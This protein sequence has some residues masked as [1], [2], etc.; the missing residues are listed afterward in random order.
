MI[1]PQDFSL[2]VMKVLSVVLLNPYFSSITN[3]LY[4]ENG[5]VSISLANMIIPKK[6]RAIRISLSA[7]LRAI[8][9]TYANP[10][11]KR[12]PSI[13]SN[14]KVEVTTPNLYLSFLY[15]CDFS[16]SS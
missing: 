13:N 12:K 16:Y 6:I 15:R 11:K 7:R 4:Q 14:E 2:S 10:S 8:E 9:S 1:R 5:K 3:V